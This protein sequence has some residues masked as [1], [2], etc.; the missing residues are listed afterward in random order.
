MSTFE[1][2]QDS[3]FV[4]Y[5]EYR[6]FISI[7]IILVVEKCSKD[8]QRLECI[9][10]WLFSQGHVSAFWKNQSNEKIIDVVVVQVVQVPHLLLLLSSKN[11]CID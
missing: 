5:F 10:M 8:F 4:T 6:I 3:S 11:V 9:R 2:H 1:F 7:F